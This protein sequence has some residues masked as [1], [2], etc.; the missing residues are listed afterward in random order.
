MRDSKYTSQCIHSDFIKRVSPTGVRRT[1]GFESRID[2]R[3]DGNR[4]LKERT[5]IA[6][7]ISSMT[8]EYPPTIT[9]IT[10][11]ET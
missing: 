7:T 8:I 10:T 5:W 6:T 9:E 1:Q 4:T 11:D 2:S 3:A